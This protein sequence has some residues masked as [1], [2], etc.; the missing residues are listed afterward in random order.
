MESADLDEAS[1]FSET[2]EQAATRIIREAA[3]FAAAAVSELMS[4][5]TVSSSVRFRAAQY[6]IDRNLGP[7]NSDAGKVDELER[8]LTELNRE[9]NEGGGRH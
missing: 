4:D 1:N 8:F 7:V 3:P 5:V 9:A 6:I 2:P